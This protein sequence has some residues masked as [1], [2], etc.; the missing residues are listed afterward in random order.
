MSEDLKEDC[1]QSKLLVDMIRERLVEQPN[2]A[3]L[4]RESGV[5][6]GTIW[7]VRNGGDMQLSSAEKL[8]PHLFQGKTLKLD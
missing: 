7:N 6:I 5:N 2:F 1:K 3:L 8:V 4:A